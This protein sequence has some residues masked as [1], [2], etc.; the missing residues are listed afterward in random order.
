MTGA[1]LIDYTRFLVNDKAE[2]QLWPDDLIVRYLQEAEALFCRMTHAY[3]VSDA[4][5]KTQAG[6][7][8]YEIPHNILRVIG[9]STENNHLVEMFGKAIHISQQNKNGEPKGYAT[10]LSPDRIVFYPTP[11]AEY[12]VTFVAASLPEI[13]LQASSAGC[14]TVPSQYH[15]VL[16]D[17]AA[18]KLLTSHDIDETSAPLAQKY[19]QRWYEGVRD[20]KRT[21]YQYRT[22]SRAHISKWTGG[23]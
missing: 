19:E 7:N 4:T 22:P 17:Y 1:E 3:V 20:A 11:D 8:T 12:T 16:C 10:G 2:P 14:M 23:K 18:A 21:M 6:V 5:I 9:A 15:Y 13:P